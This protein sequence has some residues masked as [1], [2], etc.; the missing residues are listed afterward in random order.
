M[1]IRFLNRFLNFFKK[2]KK[3][4]LTREQ[5]LV[6]MLEDLGQLRGAIDDVLKQKL[7]KTARKQFWRDF[8]KNELVRED[9]FSELLKHKV[10]SD[11][12]LDRYVRVRGV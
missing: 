4:K 12:L 9:V 5:K 7:T 6:I 10:I 2:F 8:H 1:K 3:P 11:E